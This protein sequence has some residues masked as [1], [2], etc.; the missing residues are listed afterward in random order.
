M[1]NSGIARTLLPLLMASLLT[2]SL[3]GCG[4]SKSSRSEDDQDRSTQEQPEPSD[5]GQG[6]EEIPYPDA[7]HIRIPDAV[8]AFYHELIAFDHL[9]NQVIL[10][11]N[12]IVEEESNPGI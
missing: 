10:I 12:T 6:N 7:D 9:K 5:Q 1:Y 3:V 2:V 8:M 4:G 11:A